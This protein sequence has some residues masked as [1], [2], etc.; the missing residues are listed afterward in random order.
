MNLAVF[1]SGGGSNLQAIIEAIQ[2]GTLPMTLRF[3][4]SNNSSAGALEKARVARIPAIHHSHVTC[5]S[6]IDYVEKLLK[7]LSNYSI[8]I[9]SLAGYMKIIPAEVIR[10]YRHRIVNIH[11]ALLP[12]FG[13]VGMYGLRVHEAV[14]ASG[15]SESGATVHFV[16]E[17][18]DHGEIIMQERVPVYPNDS[19]ETLA[20]RVLQVEHKIYPEAL[21]KIALGMINTDTL[22]T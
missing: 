10:L 4:L 7:L 5:A 15:A 21:R 2:S 9:I 16:D 20:T 1:A 8:D 14:L 18:Y 19:A 17:E 13:G 11:P 12:Q 3:V 22:T 6:E